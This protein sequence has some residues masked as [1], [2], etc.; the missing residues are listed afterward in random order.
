MGAQGV[1]REGFL[2][3]S[4][5]N[6]GEEASCPVPGVGGRQEEL[7]ASSLV[8]PEWARTA[9]SRCSPEQDWHRP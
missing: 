8:E 4:P 1:V 5:G 9:W 7:V 3:E 2:K 6:G